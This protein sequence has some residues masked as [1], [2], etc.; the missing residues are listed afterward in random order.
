MNAA[1]LDIVIGANVQGAVS[2][3]NQV[4][5]QLIK[6][7]K[8][9]E[10]FSTK[11]KTNFTGLNRV[12]QD[13]PFGFI[14]ISNNLEQLLPAA[15]ALG[16]VFSAVIATV[17]LLQIGFRNWTGSIK[18][19][20]EE[21]DEFTKSLRSAEQG[22]VATGVK[23]QAFV[24]IAKDSNRPLEERNN[25]LR[26]A[27]SILGE[28][29]KKLT[30]VTVGTADATT[31]INKFSQALINQA[32]ASKF[33]DRIADLIIKQKDASKAYGVALK[34]SKQANAAYE[35]SLNSMVLAEIG[36]NSAKAGQVAATSKLIKAT[37]NYKNVT[38]ELQSTNAEFFSL[39]VGGLQDVIE[40][41]KEIKVK[42][43]KVSDFFLVDTNIKDIPKKFID[44]IAVETGD[45][46]NKIV[47][48]KKPLTI[49]PLIQ[50]KP[51]FDLTD[52]EK[53]IN[54]MTNI[55][56]G[57]VIDAFAAVGEGIA[58]TISGKG[59][60]LSGIGTALGQSLEALGKYVITA[61][62]LISKI[63]KVLEAA[64]IGNPILGLAV[65]VGLIALGKL[66]STTPKFASGGIVTKPTLALVGENGPERITPLGYEGM[67]N[68]SFSGNV[69]FLIAGTTLRG[70]LR[71]ADNSASFTN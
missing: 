27:N 19:N 13:L 70:I 56:T 50:V 30:L 12:I 44:A 41:T 57:G 64:F 16:T 39:T 48:D 54:D 8:T 10:N 52:L 47:G 17:T 1:E 37:T 6:T 26:E 71:R 29:A 2:G 42:P 23:L 18:A 40:K 4:N 51:S 34:E 9:A 66:L 11:T 62:L 5:T 20:K 55:V 46:L 24:D 21:I 22:A 35:E 33:A 68:N 28:H 43:I 65:G 63:K 58:N 59:G 15:G 38:K 3:L 60:F 14:A 49:T 61:S 36:D 67:A 69:E 45:H 7:E 31:E 25:A 53:R 32:L